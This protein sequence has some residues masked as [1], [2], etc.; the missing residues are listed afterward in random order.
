MHL[1]VGLPLQLSALFRLFDAPE[2]E[3]GAASQL[4]DTGRA[5]VFIRG[6]VDNGPLPTQLC[7]V[8]VRGIN[9]RLTGRCGF[10]GAEVC[11]TRDHISLRPGRNDT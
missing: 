6:V 4:E 10:V 7:A 2:R 11:L 1:D 5:D 3:R 8:R 9:R